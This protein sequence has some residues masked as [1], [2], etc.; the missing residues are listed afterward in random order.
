MTFC[1]TSHIGKV[2][3]GQSRKEGYIEIETQLVNNVEKMWT[4]VTL[5]QSLHVCMYIY[6]QSL[7]GQILVITKN[8]TESKKQCYNGNRLMEMIESLV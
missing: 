2:I 1:L 7:T 3:R 5:F 6:H 8:V 4:I